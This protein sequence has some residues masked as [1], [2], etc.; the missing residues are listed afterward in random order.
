MTVTKIEEFDKKRVKIYIDYE[1]AFV[2][3]KGELRLY[4]L[5]ENEKIE[6]EVFEEITLELLPKRAKLRSM[7]LL[8]AKTYTEKQLRDKLKQGEYTEKLIDEA[9]EYVKSYGYI[10]DYQYAKDFILYNLEVKTRKRI[11]IDLMKKG[12]DIKI[13]QEIYESMREN[14]EISDEISLAVKLLDKRKYNANTASIEEKRK[15]SAFLY[16]KGF[17]ADT[18]RRALSLDITSI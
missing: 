8:K 5:Q 15:V 13:I 9:L 11:E 18:I 1:F 16:R 10:N 14:G 7:N 4:K 12:I 2:L 3:Y 6:K 17:S